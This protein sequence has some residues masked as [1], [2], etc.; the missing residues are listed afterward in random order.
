MAPPRFKRE[1]DSLNVSVIMGH[2][3]HKA[4]AE[5]HG[6]LDLGR[7]G[8]GVLGVGL[9]RLQR[10]RWLPLAVALLILLFSLNHLK[11]EIIENKCSAFFRL[12]D[13]DFSAGGSWP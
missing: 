13:G 5:L 12:A 6:R 9:V 10:R 8:G 4:G 7:V 3:A 2:L 1:A 11:G